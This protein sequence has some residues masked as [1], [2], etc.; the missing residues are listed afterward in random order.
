M[1]KIK[2]MPRLISLM[3]F[4]RSIFEKIK[5]EKISV[6]ELSRATGIKQPTL[7]KAIFGDRELTFSNAVSISSALGLDFFGDKADEGFPTAPIIREMK[8]FDQVAVAKPRLWDE[9]IVIEGR[10]GR[11]CIAVDRCLFDC[12][13]FPKE[14]LVIVDLGDDAQGQEIYNKGSHVSLRSDDGNLIGFAIGLIIRN[15]K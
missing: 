14:S 3:E 11:C 7:H 13:I 6:S 10:Y 8:C 2:E 15:A 12:K 4:K 9:C 5:S 1:R